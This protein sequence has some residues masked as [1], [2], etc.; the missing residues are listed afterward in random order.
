MCRLLFISTTTYKIF[1][2]DREKILKQ[3]IP[4]GTPVRIPKS[5]TVPDVAE[6]EPKCPKCGKIHKIY[7]K[8]LP[9]PKIDDDLKRKGYIPFPKDNKI[10]CDCGYEFDLGGI[11]NDIEI[12]TGKKIL[13]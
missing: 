10:K 2:I 8:L 1:V 12:K 3:A 13:E 7:A 5:Q 11:R 9:N 6:L 4:S